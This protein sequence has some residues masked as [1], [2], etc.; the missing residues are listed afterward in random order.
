MNICANA[1]KSADGDAEIARPDMARPDNSA[2]YRKDWRDW[3]T[4]HQIKQIA[5]G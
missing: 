5:T 1:F 3:T 4:R 2:P